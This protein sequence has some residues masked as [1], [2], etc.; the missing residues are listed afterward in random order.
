MG[1]LKANSNISK[2]RITHG[3]LFFTK[4]RMP[5]T[6]SIQAV[7]YF[8]VCFCICLVYLK[9]NSVTIDNDMVFVIIFKGRTCIDEQKT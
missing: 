1:S 4:N 7:M 2:Y 8:S 3:I 9:K 5:S 6:I